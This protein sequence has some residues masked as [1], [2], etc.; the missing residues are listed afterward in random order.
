MTAGIGHSIY[1]SPPFPVTIA[2][3]RSVNAATVSDCTLKL[4]MLAE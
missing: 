1:I 2:L 3:S 4:I